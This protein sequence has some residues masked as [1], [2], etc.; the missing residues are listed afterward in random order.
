MVLVG[1]IRKFDRKN[2]L[3]NTNKLDSY[4]IWISKV[5]NI[6]VLATASRIGGALSIGSS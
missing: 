2:L 4:I 6:V 5:M 1:A 3:V